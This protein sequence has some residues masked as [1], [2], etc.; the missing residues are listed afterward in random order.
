MLNK[1]CHFHEETPIPPLLR[2]GQK[3]LCSGYLDSMGKIISF[4]D[5][6]L[7]SQKTKTNNLPVYYYNH[8]KKEWSFYYPQYQKEIIS[9]TSENPPRPTALFSES[10]LLQHLAQPLTHHANICKSGSWQEHELQWLVLNINPNLVKRNSSYGGPPK[11]HA[12]TGYNPLLDEL[13][14]L[15]SHRP[16][17]PRP[18]RDLLWWSC[19]LAFCHWPITKHQ[20]MLFFKTALWNTSL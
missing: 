4:Q 13:S 7:L 2:R 15:G 9:E 20:R 10:T 11:G 6:I 5:I 14:C 17:L 19:T 3:Q 1:L 12:A 18:I 8:F 16:R